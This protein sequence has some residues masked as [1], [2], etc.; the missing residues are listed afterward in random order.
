MIRSRVLLCGTVLLASGAAIV[1]G[2]APTGAAPSQLQAV[3]D[4]QRGLPGTVVRVTPQTDTASDCSAAWGSDPAVAFSCGPD[5]TGKLGSTTVTVPAGALPGT[6]SITV[7]QPRCD[8]AALFRTATFPIR[9]AAAPFTVS[10]T[11][12]EL[13]DLT[14]AAARNLLKNAD[15]RLGNVTGS[16]NDPGARVAFQSPQAYSPVD[17]GTA[18]DVRVAGAAPPPVTSTAST[19]TSQ[20]PLPGLRSSSGSPVAARTPNT[21]R[22][23]NPT[24]VV[25][26]LTAA[27]LLFALVAADA[28]V[29]RKRRLRAR[30]RRRPQVYLRSGRGAHSV[31]I[32]DTGRSATHTV[33]IAFHRHFTVTSGKEFR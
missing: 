15:L 31:T 23:W 25:A 13:A 12:P 7:C 29:R 11:V 20:L 22:A 5:S 19:G 26:I 33:A 4:P 32:R 8:S 9:A 10:T 2:T 14:L 1:V 28:A 21:A 17:P 27:G 16:T 30:R 3:L 18:V 6:Y 24:L